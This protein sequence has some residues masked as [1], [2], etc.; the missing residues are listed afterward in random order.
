MAQPLHELQQATLQAP[1]HLEAGAHLAAVQAADGAPIYVVANRDRSDIVAHSTAKDGT[2]RKLHI[3]TS[4]VGQHGRTPRVISTSTFQ[5]GG[6]T[7][8]K[9][10]ASLALRDRQFG[11]GIST[12]DSA[13]PLLNLTLEAQAG[14]KLRVTGTHEGVIDADHLKASPLARWIED[15][16]RALAAK[17]AVF[18]P[19]VKRA[20]QRYQKRSANAL[21]AAH[22]KSPG[23]VLPHIL[24]GRASTTNSIIKA[25]GWCLAGM[26][27]A[28]V[29]APETGGVSVGAYLAICGAGAGASLLGDYVDS[30]NPG[31][32]PGDGGQ[33]GETPNSSGPDQGGDDGGDWGGD[34]GADGAGGAGG[35]G[36][37]GGAGGGCFVRGTE[38]S[39]PRGPVPIDQLAVGDEVLA[40]D[41]VACAPTVQRIE[42]VFEFHEPEVM[43]LTLGKDRVQCT[44]NHRFFTGGWTA[45]KKLVIGEAIL[46]RDG[47]WQTLNDI[48]RAASPQTVFNLTVAEHHSYYVGPSGLLVHNRKDDE[49]ETEDGDDDVW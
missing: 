23:D 19:L 18:T 15:A 4:I 33:H 1:A 10:V 9:V 34:D 21:A 43:T 17:L 12:P 45:A 8:L 47:G 20:A 6:K 31:G 5:L 25:E 26:I 48:S 7:V 49:P 14:R 36:G 32:A 3:V 2:E 41:P 42:K 35:E 13:A 16:C 28:A 30:T 38:V 37:G 46:R 44:P 24:S 27:A 39:T 29:T 22:L 11:L 40:Y